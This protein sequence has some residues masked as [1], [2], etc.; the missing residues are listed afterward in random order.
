MREQTKPATA[1]SLADAAVEVMQLGVH[2][3]SSP[4][5]RRCGKQPRF[6]VSMLDPASGRT[7]LM[8]RCECGDTSS[9]TEALASTDN[10]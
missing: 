6:V 8:F 10:R 4:P 1:E 5:C 2:K 9:W 7:V 3:P